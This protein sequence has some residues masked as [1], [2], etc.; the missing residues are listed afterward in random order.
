M[1]K[2][3]LLVAVFAVVLDLGRGRFATY[4]HLQPRSIRVKEGDTV[5]SGDML[6]LVGNS[7]ANAPHLHFQVTDGPG[8]MTS[9]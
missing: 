7:G 1:L 6:G 8:P 3:V 5:R 2:W 4:F 9:D